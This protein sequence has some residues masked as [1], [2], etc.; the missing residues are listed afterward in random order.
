MSTQAKKPT[1]W[2]EKVLAFLN[3]SDADKVSLMKKRMEKYYKE[4]ERKCKANIEKLTRDLED[5]LETSE[6]KLQEITEQ[7]EGAFLNVNLDAIKTVDDR[8]YYVS[9][10]DDQ[11]NRAIKLR[12]QKE[13]EIEETKKS[14]EAHI[15]LYKEKLEMIAYK[16]SKLK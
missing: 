15:A 8:E 14:N 6:E 7:E 11:F 4:E 12:K 3:V 2:V 10:L 1:T 5:Y 13:Q 16:K 9:V